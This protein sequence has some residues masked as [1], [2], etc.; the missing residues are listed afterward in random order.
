MMPACRFGS[1]SIS[2]KHAIFPNVCTKF[3]VEYKIKICLNL[4]NINLSELSVFEFVAF[5]KGRPI[6]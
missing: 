2:S 6:I 4:K 5:L 1:N 3:I